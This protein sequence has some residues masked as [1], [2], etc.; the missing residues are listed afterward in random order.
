MLKEIFTPI[1]SYGNKIIGEKTRLKENNL[2]K[3]IDI[4]LEQNSFLSH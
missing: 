3:S 1:Q 4:K 2:I